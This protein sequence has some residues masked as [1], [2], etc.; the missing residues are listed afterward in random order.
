MIRN[1]AFLSIGLA[2]HTCV[3]CAE[4]D[5]SLFSTDHE[6]MI[7]SKLAKGENIDS[8]ELFIALD[9]KSLNIPE[10]VKRYISGL[11]QKTTALPMNRR[12]KAIYNGVHSEFLKKYVEEA[13][14]NDIFITGNY[15]CVTA[16]ALY[17]L[18]L[19]EL[20]IEFMIKETPDHVYIVADP[21][22]TAFVI[23][24]TLPGEKILKF[25]DRLKTQY[26]EY[27]HNNKL[28]SELEFTDLSTDELFEKHYL[29]DKTISV[30]RLAGLQYYNKGAFL[31]EKERFND[32]RINFEKARLLNDHEMIS[33]MLNNTFIN[34]MENEN[35]VKSFNGHIL[36]KYVNLNDSN[37]LGLEFAREF[38]Q[39]VSSELIINKPRLETYQKYFND[40]YQHVNSAD[41][42]EI[43]KTYYFF[44]GYH[45]AVNYEYPLALENLEAA[46]K[47]N[48]EN[49]LTRQLVAECIMKFLSDDLEYSWTNDS[50]NT[51]ISRF[52]FLRNDKGIVHLL[53][54]SYFISMS[55][56]LHNNDYKTASELLTGFESFLKEFPDFKLDVNAG[57][58]VYQQFGYYHISMNQYND[59]EKYLRKGIRLFPENSYL[60]NQ[61][62]SVMSIRGGSYEY[63]ELMD[64]KNP[65]KKYLLALAIAKDN[66]ESTNQNADKYLKHI[67]KGNTGEQD[68][69]LQIMDNNRA[70]IIDANDT[71]T[72]SW[73]YN[74]DRGL[75]AFSAD[76]RKDRINI[77]ITQLLPDRLKGIIYRGEDYKNAVDVFLKPESF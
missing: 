23:E 49:I 63:P 3:F 73:T 71:L 21:H 64:D 57:A 58:S 19:Q 51:Y 6:K 65:M 42:S 17:A 14:F 74:R 27:L 13:Y 36:A 40:F 11:N 32:A 39:M 59:A 18:I 43:K 7:F 41:I 75:F 2:I 76:H 37:S 46:Y 22:N 34:L 5:T 70:Q 16:S 52:P 25:D 66:L 77:I 48:N 9:F 29:K 20:A 56:S 8:L 55:N 72:G 35:R 62:R 33:Y 24:T 45:H 38:F 4:P 12:L 15:N 67:W 69:T 44:L 54:N 60:K 1:I 10:T 61:L 47:L 68:L 53:G 28:I 30:K 26:V 50:L 31:Y